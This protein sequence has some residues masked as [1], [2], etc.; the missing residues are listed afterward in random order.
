MERRARR[1]GLPVNSKAAP[2]PPCMH[3]QYANEACWW[4]PGLITEPTPA[5]STTIS[6]LPLPNNLS[7]CPHQQ[8]P[9]SRHSLPQPEDCRVARQGY[10]VRSHV[11]DPTCTED[12]S[13][14]STV[15]IHPR[16]F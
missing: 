15:Y 14:C 4:A 12:T 2:G 11:F 13:M 1:P 16:G 5:P 3:I 7:G 8:C 10:V 9:P 6:S